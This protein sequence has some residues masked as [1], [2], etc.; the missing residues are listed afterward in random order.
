MEIIGVYL[1]HRPTSRQT[2]PRPESDGPRR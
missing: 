2:W 1:L